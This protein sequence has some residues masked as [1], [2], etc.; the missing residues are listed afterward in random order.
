MSGAALHRPVEDRVDGLQLRRI[1]LSHA[2]RLPLELGDY[3]V[4]RSITSVVLQRLA[5]I[6]DSGP[7]RF[8]RPEELLCIREGPEPVVLNGVDDHLSRI[9]CRHPDVD[10]RLELLEYISLS[11]R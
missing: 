8:G 3:F 7:F 6:L 1:P 9:V 11:C 4:R 2:E 5:T 10:A